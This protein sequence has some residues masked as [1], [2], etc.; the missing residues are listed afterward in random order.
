[1]YRDSAEHQD[2]TIVKQLFTP[3]PERRRAL[4]QRGD[5]DSEKRQRRAGGRRLANGS[6][7]LGV[8]GVS[9]FV[10]LCGLAVWVT[11]RLNRGWMDVTME[12]QSACVLVCNYQCALVL[13]YY[14]P[15][16]ERAA[17]SHVLTYTLTSF[18]SRCG[19]L[20]SCSPRVAIVRGMACCQGS[21]HGVHYSRHKQRHTLP[22][23]QTSRC[24]S[25]T[26]PSSQK[27]VLP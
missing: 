12:G 14:D 1:M 11:I 24:S 2:D 6:F 3:S 18:M 16:F 4:K 27:A 26:S 7:S 8:L 17:H 9:F 5:S 20:I 25:V 10:L 21:V 23:P 22:S 15:W 13:A 19:A